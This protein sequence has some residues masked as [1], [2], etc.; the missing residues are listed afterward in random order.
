MESGE[1]EPKV[2]KGPSATPSLRLHPILS[3]SSSGI[4]GQGRQVLLP[5][6]NILPAELMH[7][8][9]SGPSDKVSKAIPFLEQ[10]PFGWWPHSSCCSRNP[11]LCSTFC[12]FVGNER[13]VKRGCPGNHTCYP[14]LDSPLWPFWQ[15]FQDFWI[16][17]IYFIYFLY[18]YAAF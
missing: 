17:C 14:H 15:V 8:P 7:L 3:P 9:S 2:C 11:P 5:P 4:W 12:P 10:E 16:W 18:L 6:S 1:E 13:A